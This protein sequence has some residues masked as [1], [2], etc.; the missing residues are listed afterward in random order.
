[1]LG[2]RHKR[3]APCGAAGGT[4]AL[5][6][7]LVLGQYPNDA[8]D[9]LSLWLSSHPRA[10]GGDEPCI[11]RLPPRGGINATGG[12]IRGGA[13]EDPNCATARVDTLVY[14]H[15]Q[16]AGG[17]SVKDALVKLCSRCRWVCWFPQLSGLRRWTEALV[18]ED[19]KAASYVERWFALPQ[20]ARDATRVLFGDQGRAIAACEY[21]G[22]R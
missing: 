15:N 12:R 5:L 13:L 21:V 16:K 8:T 7:G 9:K 17:T 20:H 14:A 11:V 18:P 3:R 22:G 6:V 19:L 4:L 2:A 1:M 10:R